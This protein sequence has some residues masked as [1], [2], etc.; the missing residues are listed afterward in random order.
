MPEKWTGRLIGKMHNE[1]VTFDELGA[2]MGVGKAY[3][4]MILN[5]RRKP[6]GIQ[7]RMEKAFESV[8]DKRRGDSHER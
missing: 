4:S 6:A 7:E 2:E 8:L 5:S 1:C 3:V